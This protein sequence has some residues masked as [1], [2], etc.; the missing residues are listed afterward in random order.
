MKEALLLYT[1]IFTYC[2][3]LLALCYTIYIANK[4][5]LQKDNQTPALLLY[6]LLVIFI[7]SFP[8]KGLGGDR[9]IYA[10]GFLHA[11]EWKASH[12]V[13]FMAYNYFCRKIME[14]DMWFFLTG[15]LY[16]LGI[17]QLSRKKCKVESTAL[18]VGYITFLFF[19]GYAVNT[20]RAGLAASLLL[21]ALVWRDSNKPIYFSLLFCATQIHSSM[22]LPVIALVLS[23]YYKN[24]KVYF[25]FWLLCIPLSYLAGSY[26]QQLAQPLV[27]DFTQR[28]IKGYLIEKDKMYKSG[29][30]FDF[31]IYSL[32]PALLAYYYIYKK[33]VRD[34]FYTNIINAY[35]IANGIW[36]LVIRANFSD[37]FGYL[38]W[39]FIPL[40][41]LYPAL[42]YKIWSKQQQK[43][44]WIIFLQALFTFVLNIR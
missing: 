1:T 30:R 12:D 15:F 26:F 31:I 42:N 25:Y 41:L 39:V 5:R 32:I 27:T 9:E 24:T 4:D 38:S 23:L 14:L 40:L 35:L 7:G 8:Y 20:M 3:F 16:V 18:F 21:Y 2:S 6:A 44:G 33:K 19:S 37:R 11:T 29:F 13:L 34:S 22:W 28:N 17:Y 10:Q 36:I 43:I